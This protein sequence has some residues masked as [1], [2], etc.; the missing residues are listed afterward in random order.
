MNVS[1]SRGG[2]L[3]GLTV[4]CATSPASLG[5]DEEH[6]D[7]RRRDHD[8][9]MAMKRHHEHGIEMAQ[10]VLR[11]G[12]D[13]PVKQFAQKVVTQQQ[14]EIAELEKWLQ[15]HAPAKAEPRKAASP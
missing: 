12:K 5:R 7:D 9:A 8:F 3:V 11:D 2:I 4:T 13:P 6:E 14:S 15:A 1:R 10:I